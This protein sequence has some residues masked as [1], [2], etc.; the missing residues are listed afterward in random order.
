MKDGMHLCLQLPRRG[1]CCGRVFPSGSSKHSRTFHSK[2]QAK[3][4]FYFFSTWVT[5]DSYFD[6]PIACRSKN[7]IVRCMQ[8]Q[9]TPPV[10]KVSFDMQKNATM[11]LIV[12]VP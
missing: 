3:M 12:A 11:D 1:L 8:T 9:R 2:K 7:C 10:T 4:F 5:L 6:V